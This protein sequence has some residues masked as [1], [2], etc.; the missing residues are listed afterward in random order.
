MARVSQTRRKHSKRAREDRQF[1]R[2]GYAVAV[3]VEYNG[4]GDG[5]LSQ[6]DATALGDD[7]D[8]WVVTF[9]DATNF[10]VTSGKGGAQ[11]SG[12]TGTVFTSTDG[13]ISFLITVGGTPFVITDSFDIAVDE[14]VGSQLFLQP[15][16]AA[17]WFKDQT[18]RLIGVVTLS[19]LFGQ[20]KVPDLVRSNE[21]TTED[22]EDAT[23]PGD[24][25]LPLP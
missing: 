20:T 16:R 18:E 24:I 1:R 4:T 9:S 11:G 13:R 22:I 2:S 7:Q 8:N 12:T 21:Y 5:V 10:D 3:D 14:V 23:E 17:T 15:S 6:L 25:G 19:S